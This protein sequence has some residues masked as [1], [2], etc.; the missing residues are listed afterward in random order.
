MQEKKINKNVFA[1]ESEAVWKAMKEVEM[2]ENLS[3]V[4]QRWM[5]LILVALCI[6]RLLQ[7]TICKYLVSR[8]RKYR[9]NIF[10]ESIRRVCDYNIVIYKVLY[11]DTLYN[12]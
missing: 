12:I 9:I 6:Q 5:I 10:Q 4:I 7:L 1:E 11:T 8:R 3:A 2:C